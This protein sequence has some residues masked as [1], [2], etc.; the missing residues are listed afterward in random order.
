M[1]T[2]WEYEGNELSLRVYRRAGGVADAVNRAADATFKAL[3]SGQQDAA[4]FVFSRLTIITSDQRLARRQ[5][6][7][8]DLHIPGSLASAADVNAVIDTFAARRLL[9]LGGNTVEICH[10]VLLHAW[11]QLR[12][13]LDGD[14][15]DRA[16]YSQVITDAQTWDNNGRDPAYL[17][18]AG[19]LATIDAASTRWAGMPNRFPSLP[20]TTK[21]FL[22][23]ARHHVR[24]ASRRRHAVIVGLVGLTLAA[25]TAAGI[26]AENAANANRQHA[27]SLSRQLAADSIAIDRADPITARQ[28]AVAAWN[29][30]PTDQANSAMTTLLTEQQ[31]GG[32]LP[33]GL[34]MAQ[35]AFSSDGKLV[36]TVSEGTIR[37]WNPV[38]GQPVGRPLLADKDGNVAGVAF[39]PDGKLLAGAGADGYVR[40]W[41]P[42][43]GRPV[44]TPLP[45]APGAIGYVAGVAFSPDGR[46]L[47]GVGFGGI[48]RLW[49]PVTGRAIGAPLSDDMSDTF[50]Y[51]AGV[52]FSPD[53][54]LLAS[55]S[56]DGYVWL[57][58]PATGKPTGKPLRADA[59]L[60][61]GVNGVAFS[62]DGRLLASASTDG[63]VRLWNPVTGHPVG[64]PLAA[65]P[66]IGGGVKG[67]AF[68][69][70]GRLLASAD[71]DGT[72]RLWNPVTGH[73]V[74]APL[75]ADPG[76]GGGVKGVAFSP[77][78]NL[79]ASADADGTV[80]LWNPAT[81]HP[82]GAPFA[83]DPGIIGGVNGVAF[84]PDDGLL[85]SANADGYHTAVESSDRPARRQAPPV[86]TSA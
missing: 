76:I 9:V 4:R 42:A 8:A 32:D 75:A 31:Q 19:R 63:Y 5:C 67:V 68:S 70:D 35:V 20:A 77:D 71:A 43:T 83:A 26:A 62:P 29:V 13:W 55:A 61:D 51:V 73:P 82:V 30:F 79:L 86:P 27:I 47:A 41:N 28:L 21:A 69:P 40:L 80:R 24:R 12:T 78:G 59:G 23:A 22:D 10:D 64:A 60:A 49:N 34:G 38:T 11:K 3:T 7:R 56:T 58:N 57:W 6:S 44:G 74:G 14:R 18:Q 50:G 66:G 52:A 37:L 48:V 39:S 17:Y 85:A 81:G 84:S 16:L 65:D 53:G 46:L 25:T 15:S 2:T 45:A 72:V 36:A 33:V 1:A 54:K